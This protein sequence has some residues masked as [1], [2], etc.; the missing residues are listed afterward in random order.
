[1]ST[2]SPLPMTSSEHPAI[3]IVGL[4][5]IGGSIALDLVGKMPVSFFARSSEA[6]FSGSEAGLEIGETPADVVAQSDVIF[7]AVP[8]DQTISV[9]GSLIEHLRPGQIVTDVGSTKSKVVNWAKSTEWPS[10][11]HFIGGHPMAGTDVSGFAGAVQS[12]FR[13]RT[14]ILT[15]DDSG[16][17]SEIDALL[18]LMTVITGEL[19]AR[20]AIMDS[21]VHDRSVAM[22]SHLE[23]L[24]SLAL[25]NLLRKSDD[26]F[27]LSRLVAG[28]FIDATRVSKSAG[29]MV[30]PFL[31]Q[32]PY[33]SKVEQEFTDEMDRLSE[34]LGESDNL[35]RLWEEGSQWRSH[36]EVSGPS[37][38]RVTLANDDGLVSALKRM[39]KVGKF[40]KKLERHLNEIEID[41]G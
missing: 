39:S 9:I 40:V 19:G 28:S 33:L 22:V 17:R 41:V 30:V 12:L 29:S 35:G 31:S 6:R 27:L 10:G 13:N 23:H 5:Q 20:I 11:V 2:A 24:V 25:V 15:P 21:M 32:N 38:D 34:L 37:F 4:G 7:I 36:L 1:M 18:R 16:S 8:V 3:G 14:W 26:E